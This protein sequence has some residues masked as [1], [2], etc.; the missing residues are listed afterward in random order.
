MI[1]V[2]ERLTQAAV[3]VSGGMSQAAVSRL[4]SGAAGGMTLDAIRAV[5]SAL[6][7]RIEIRVLWRGAEL[8]KLLDERHA[9]LSGDVVRTLSNW[10]WLTQIEVS[11]S[12][13]GERGSIDILA[14]HAA[15]RSLL[16][17]E[18]KAEL[19]SIEELVR[20]LDA[21]ERLAPAIVRERYGWYPRMVSRLVVLPG[22]RSVY[23][24]VGR[25]GTLLES[26]FP[27]RGNAVR[28]WL[29]EPT[30]RLSGL[31]LVSSMREADTSRKRKAIH[32]GRARG[33]PSS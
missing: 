32:A 29:R 9:R 30:G 15:S 12:V 1:R 20:R 31:W 28:S 7:A 13:Y 8:E 23:R 14:W 27:V 33:A 17:I 10:G 6:G 24:A 3:A 21:K 19:A 26:A 2:R 4:E 16:V 5:A 25:H 18:V 11:F 22:G